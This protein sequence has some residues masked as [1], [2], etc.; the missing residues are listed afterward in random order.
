VRP[1]AGPAVP[2]DLLVSDAL[3]IIFDVRRRKILGKHR[4]YILI[5]INNCLVNLNIALPETEF[6]PH[7]GERLLSPQRDWAVEHSWSALRH[8]AGQGEMAA[9]DRRGPTANRTL[10]LPTT[11]PT[12][13]HL[14]LQGLP[15]RRLVRR[16]LA[17][18]IRRF[19][20]P[21]QLDLPD[22]GIGHGVELGVSDLAIARPGALIA[23]GL[24]GIAHAIVKLLLKLFSHGAEG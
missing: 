14:H 7:F 11:L 22:D 4:G 2:L 1:L 21:A 24:Q 12:R 10:P 9:A 5:I 20:C 6:S 19:K 17:E 15:R 13:R 8:L 3:T 23:M 18:D 16:V